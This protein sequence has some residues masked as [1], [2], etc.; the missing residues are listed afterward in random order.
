MTNRLEESV[1]PT[2]P[3]EL[4]LTHKRSFCTLHMVPFKREWPLGF[5]KATLALLEMW[6]QDPEA[7]REIDAGGPTAFYD[8]IHKLLDEKPLCCRVTK[9]ELLHAYMDSGISHQVKCYGCKCSRPGFQM[10][11]GLN[12]Q[13]IGVKRWQ[14]VC[15][16]CLLHRVKLQ[17]N[18]DQ[19]RN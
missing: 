4:V 18:N 14:P 11:V 5:S 10:E 6:M 9:Q 1:T 13:T 17:S 8:T 16:Y 2:G 3:S 19:R 15:F 7:K 12:L